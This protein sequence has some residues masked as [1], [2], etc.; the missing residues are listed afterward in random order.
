MTSISYSTDC[1]SL[2]RDP[3]YPELNERNITYIVSKIFAPKRY[4][5]T[6]ICTSVFPILDRLKA[7]MCSN[8]H[9]SRLNRDACANQKLFIREGVSRSI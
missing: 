9:F 5:Q 2:V 4:L 3:K 1:L 6:M 8:F 7:K